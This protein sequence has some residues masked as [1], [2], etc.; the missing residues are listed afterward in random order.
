[1]NLETAKRS[2]S[3]PDFDAWLTEC[4]KRCECDKQDAPCEATM[5]GL[6]C[7]SLT[8]PPFLHNATRTLWAAIRRRARKGNREP[9]VVGKDVPNIS[10][11]VK[12]N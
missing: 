3:D 11:L 4:A 6:E 9:L 5:D 12:E 8:E 7:C 10:S 2:L 1:M